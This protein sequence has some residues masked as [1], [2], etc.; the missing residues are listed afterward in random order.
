MDPFQDPLS[1]PADPPTGPEPAADPPSSTGSPGGSQEAEFERFLA[2]IRPKVRRVF[3]RYHIPRQDAED[4]LQ[5]ALL[6]AVGK[7]ELIQSKDAWLV[8]TLCH[9]CS[10]YWRDRRRSRVEEVDDERLEHLAPPQRAGQ[11]NIEHRRDL[12]RLLATL[13][14]RHRALLVL[15]Y[16]AGFSPLEVAQRLGYHEASIR[17]LACRSMEKLQR[18]ARVP[19]RRRR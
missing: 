11:E 17:K 13:E 14:S 12:R 7:W 5:D 18:A 4:L 1:P 3:A 2:G 6:A 8:A 9:K 16:G 10:I 19:G 15:R